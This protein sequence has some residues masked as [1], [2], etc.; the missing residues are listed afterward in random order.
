MS[1]SGLPA[2]ARSAAANCDELPSL[3][4]TVAPVAFS[5]AATWHA[6]RLS[7]KDPP[8]EPTTS[9]SAEPGTIAK[10]KPPIA[11]ADA[12]YRRW[13]RM[14]SLACFKPTAP[15]ARRDAALGQAEHRTVKFIFQE[16][17]LKDIL[18]TWRE[19]SGFSPSRVRLGRRDP[20]ETISHARR[21]S[22]GCGERSGAGAM[23][24]RSR[25]RRH[26]SL[27]SRISGDRLF[28]QS[29][30]WPPFAPARDFP[31]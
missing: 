17:Y 25:R 4:D 2:A 15:I 5:K 29:G 16:R 12:T 7:A 9:S 21:S 14:A 6:L 3:S 30:G 10:A 22:T 27:A 1:M 23:G 31:D 18:A 19:A 8:N 13:A 24:E 26:G 20:K 11:A 28:G